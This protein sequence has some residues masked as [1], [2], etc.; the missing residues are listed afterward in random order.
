MAFNWTCPHCNRDQTVTAGMAK[1]NHVHVAIDDLADGPVGLAMLTIGCANTKCKRLYMAVSVVSD[2]HVAGN[3]YR[4]SGAEPIL[5]LT[6]IPRGSAKPQPDYVP[7]A[8]VEDYYEACL[9]R[10]DSPKAAATL[11]RRCLQ[12]MIRD[13]CG[14]SK[15]TL[16]EEIVALRKAVEDHSAPQGVTLESVDAID[17]VRGVG[18]IGA[19]MEADVGLIIPVEADEAQLLINLIEMLIKEWY[20]ERHE[21]ATR[22]AAIRSLGVAKA[23]AVKAVKATIASA[24]PEPSKETDKGVA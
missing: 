20:V 7:A 4:A 5:E 13:F 17:H 2:E 22:L 3:V 12:G 21:R 19:H 18:N 8:I 9:I 10:D 15:R 23:E 6:L 1:R 24:K 14:I 11:A 16:L